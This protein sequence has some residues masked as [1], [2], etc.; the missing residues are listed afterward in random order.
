MEIAL[1]ALEYL[2]LFNEISNMVLAE[3]FKELKTLRDKEENQ[4]SCP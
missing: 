4:K 3:W 1:N 2:I